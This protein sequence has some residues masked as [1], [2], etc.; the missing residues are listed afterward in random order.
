MAGTAQ[1]AVLVVILFLAQLRAAESRSRCEPI[2]IPLCQNI[3]YNEAVFP[4][5]LNHTD[6]QEA[7][8]EVHQFFPLV[9][10]NCSL[11]LQRFLCSV[12]APNCTVH[13]TPIP[14]CRSLCLEVQN[15]CLKSMERFG[16]SWPGQLR[17]D[18][19]PLFVTGTQCWKGEVENRSLSEPQ[20]GVNT[21]KF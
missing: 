8:Q 1:L 9:K 4:N 14:P 17:C 15:G 6:Q 12:Y 7:G 5:L 13:R 19:Y 21:G 3:Q 2:T 16:F 18:Q 11:Y 10:I 20:P